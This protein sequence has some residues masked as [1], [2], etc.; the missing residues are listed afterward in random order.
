MI[1]GFAFQRIF[2]VLYS[3]M[4]VRNQ[5]VED[6]AIRNMH[7]KQYLNEEIYLLNVSD[8]ICDYSLSNCIMA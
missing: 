6:N 7:R 8:A 5:L 2:D 4:G 3:R 1:L